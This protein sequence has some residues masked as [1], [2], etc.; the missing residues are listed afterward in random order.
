M[1]IHDEIEGED[2]T[3]SRPDPQLNGIIANQDIAV[4]RAD[5]VPKLRIS[6]LSRYG[7]RDVL[8]LAE[9]EPNLSVWHRKT[10]EYLIATRWRHRS[11]IATIA[12]IASARFARHLVQAFIDLAREAGFRLAVISE[13]I[14]SRP[15]AFYRSVGMD[16]LESIIVYEIDA[17]KYLPPAPDGLDF[18]RLDLT[19]EDSM[20]RLT[21][22][23][24]SAFP[25]LWWNSLDEFADYYHSP[26]VTIWLGWTKERELGA[27]V[28][29]TSLR[30]WGHLDRIA[31]APRFQGR[32]YGRQSLDH[33]IRAL[34]GEGAK[35]IALS[36]QSSNRVSRSLY[37]S[38]GFTRSKKHDY[39]IWGRWLTDDVPAME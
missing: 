34:S 6:W 37:E 22:L 7:F 30:S 35:K 11:E 36:T 17:P 19:D 2:T 29:V 15:E 10:G 21:D 38:Y 16:V 14:E 8:S 27:Y 18:T 20:A 26:G 32:G 3:L 13:Y 12:E 9:N 28:G 39:R 31:V 5:D 23:D 4:L 25:W 24:R 33:A 1:S